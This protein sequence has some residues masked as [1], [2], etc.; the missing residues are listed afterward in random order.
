LANKQDVE[1]AAN[2][3]EVFDALDLERLRL[4]LNG[5]GAAVTVE[6]AGCSA[7]SRAAVVRALAGVL[8]RQQPGG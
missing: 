2:A 3:E 6:C 1:G 7:T 4:E 5:G 8:G